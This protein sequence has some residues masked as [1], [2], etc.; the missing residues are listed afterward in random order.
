MIYYTD[1]ANAEQIFDR[2]RKSADKE[3][4]IINDCYGEHFGGDLKA[5]LTDLINFENLKIKDL[6]DGHSMLLIDKKSGGCIAEIT[7]DCSYYGTLI[8]LWNIINNFDKKI[9]ISA[10]NVDI[11]KHD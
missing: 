9:K 8:P 4:G 3:W 6:L 1:K 11:I 5:D 7:A 2:I 10:Y